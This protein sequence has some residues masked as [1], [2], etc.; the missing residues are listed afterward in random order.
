MLAEIERQRRLTE[1]QREEEQRLAI[2]PQ[3]D[4]RRALYEDSL[5]EFLKAAWPYFDPS[6]WQDGWCIEA[7]AEHLQ[8]V[9]DGQITRLI[10]NI[11][12]RTG[13][14]LADDTPVLTTAGWKTHGDLHVGDCV[15]HP[16]GKPVRVMAVSDKTPSDVRVEFFDG[17]VIYCHEAHEWRLFNRMSRIWETVEARRFLEPKRGRW[18][19]TSG[20]IKRA[21]SGSRALHQLPQVDALQMPE[22]DLDMHPY[23]LGAWLGDGSAGKCCITHAKSDQAYIDKIVSLGYPVSTVSVHKTTGVHTSNFAGAG[24]RNNPPRMTRELRSLGVFKDKHIPET[25]LLAAAEQRLELLAG[26]I[27]TDG[28]MDK[29]GR[30]HISTVQRRLADGIADLVRTFGW[31]VSLTEVKPVFK[32]GR[33]IQAKRSCWVVGFQVD[34]PLPVALARKQPKRFA[35]RRAIGLKS[36]THDPRGKVGRCIQVDAPDG[37]YLVGKHLTPTHN[38]SLLSVAFPAWCWAQSE[39]SVT[40]GAG[41]RFLFASYA[42]RLSRRDSLRCARLMNSAWYQQLWG[43]RF[44]LVQDSAIRLVN[45]VG[46]ERLI[47]SIPQGGATGEGADVFILDDANATNQMGEATIESTNEWWDQTASTR[48][49]DI[50]RG[51]FINV[52][53]RTG[54]EDLTGHILERSVGEWTHLCLPMRFETDRS[55]VT[56][57]GRDSDGELIT[58]E[59]PRTFEGELLWEAR[60]GEAE[61]ASLERTLGPWAAAGQLQQ[62]P[63]PKGGGVIKRDWWNLW[64]TKGP[65]GKPQDFPPFDYIV[66]SVDTAFTTKTENDYSAMTVWG[67]FTINPQTTATRTLDRSGAVIDSATYAAETPRVML[68]YAWQE[69]L[70]LHD[71]V[72]KVAKTNRDMKVDMCLVEAKASGLSVGQELRRLHSH[73]AWGVM[74]KDPKS[75]DKLARLHSVAPLFA[76]EMKRN[77]RGE[78]VIARPGIVYAPDRAWA[79]LVMTQVGMFPKGKFDDL[80]DTVSQALRHLRDIGLLQLAPERIAEVEESRQFDNV[81]RLDPLYPG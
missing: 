16:S 12:P 48:L 31:R 65:D 69:R 33:T 40:S 52:Q 72:A 50:K 75:M 46:G 79:D 13:K 63:E 45:D 29:N 34:R 80:V 43:E 66:S 22:A 25:Y 24:G 76:P 42:E 27:D 14:Q 4:E 32:P 44:S 1:Q 37:L 61:V 10:V 26:L 7:L 77:A 11:P 18:G 30:A 56:V 41:V 36:I 3:V 54:E 35:P 19:V 23:V 74:L 62:R 64:E 59:D 20:R 38:S 8:A 17:S 6:H 57:L 39:R 81:K 5:Y 47:T 9:V 21:L 15:F 55:F 68:M 78:E 58:W 49:N 71:L 70:E 60:F 67:V 2:Q 28:C 73:E 53:Q 51:A